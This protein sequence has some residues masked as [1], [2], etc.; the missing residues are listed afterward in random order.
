[1]FYV[2]A[3]KIENKIMYVGKGTGNRAYDVNSRSDLWKKVFKNI[4]PVIEIIE[5]FNSESE[6]L[7][8]EDKIIIKHKPPCNIRMV[9][10]DNDPLKNASFL[11]R[12]SEREQIKNISFNM[13]IS[14]AIF[15]RRALE[16]FGIKINW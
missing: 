2:Y 14:Q 10:N 11:I 3:H 16:K 4:I 1:M 7:K 13:G 15:V 8:L 12:Q 5:T 6:S 9:I